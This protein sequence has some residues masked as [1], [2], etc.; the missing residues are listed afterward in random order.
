MP[1]ERSNL[2][3]LTGW[4]TFVTVLLLVAFAVSPPLG[5]SEGPRTPRIVIHAK[6]FA[7]TPAEI[8]LK[9]GK[10]TKLILISDDVT[11]GLV[12]EGLAITAEI[13][14][15]RKTVVSVTPTQSGDFVGSCSTFCGSGHRDMEFVIHVV[16]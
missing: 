12:V 13:R 11:H 6:R 5:R 9:K 4:R 16:D 8:A 1:L 14:K 10:T 7:F 2:S 3:A 15:G